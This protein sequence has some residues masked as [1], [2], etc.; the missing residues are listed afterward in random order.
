MK[1]HLAAGLLLCAAIS[2]GC[3]NTTLLVG[4]QRAAIDS[5]DVVVYFYERPR[6]HF[7]T[8]AWIDIKHG[9]FGSQQMLA[10]MRKAAAEVGA[11]GLVLLQS[12]Q[13]SLIETAGSAK[14]IR[15][16]SG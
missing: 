11:S 8:V 4:Q 6:C 5:D 2:G 13:L 16:L 1:R 15:C 9:V 12:Q 14:A 3:A 10:N 7:E